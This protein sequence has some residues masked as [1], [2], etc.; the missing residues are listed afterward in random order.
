MLKKKIL[1]LVLFTA[2]GFYGCDDDEHY[3]DTTPPAPPANVETY[4]ADEVVEIIWDHNNESDVA[5]YN[6][7]Y[8][9]T[10][11]GEYTLIGSVDYD[12]NSFVDYDV[13]N[14][15]KYYYAVAA[16]DFNG[17]E[18]E[19]SYDEVYGVP[20][21][22]GLN[23]SIFDYIKFPSS[24]GYDFSEYQVGP[25]DEKIDG[26]SADFFFENYEGTFYLNVW[27]DTD[28]QDMGATNSIYD[29]TYAPL[30]GW[31]SLVDGENVKYVEVEVGHTYVIYTWDSHYAKVRISAM[32][33][34]RI[35]FD[36]AYQ[37][38]EGERQLKVNRNL[39]RDELPQEIIK[40][41]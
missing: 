18:S 12:I 38:V 15:V 10:Y 13:E 11:W 35:I 34:E 23:Q 25:F 4:V 16:Y 9:Y 40:N 26:F 29:I 27:D 24:S 32:T 5:G 33:S 19:L 39:K 7:Y 14:G 28:I 6:I 1:T 22:E 8:S 36:W 30:T 3:I 21:P 31:V 41:K 2:I 20:R 17:N 37:L